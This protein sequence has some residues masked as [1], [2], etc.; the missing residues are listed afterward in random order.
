[1]VNNNVMILLSHHWNIDLQNFLQVTPD[2]WHDQLLT[3]K[4]RTIILQVVRKLSH[5]LISPA[6]LS[7]PN[8]ISD[9]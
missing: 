5:R 7:W 4:Q 1:M 2:S 3:R 9:P 6:D 8:K